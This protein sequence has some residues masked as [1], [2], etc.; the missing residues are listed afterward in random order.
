MGDATSRDE[1]VDRAL[2]WVVTNVRYTGLEFGKQALVPVAPGRTL[3]RG[4]G[5]CKD[6]STLLVGIL[7]ER[8]VDAHVALLNAGEWYDVPATLPGLGLFDH[9]IVHVGG[10]EPLWA[11]PTDRH[12]RAGVLPEAD[13]GRLAL[14]ASPTTR[15]PTRT[16]VAGVDAATWWEETTLDIEDGGGAR[17]HHRFGATGHI[18]SELRAGY[19]GNK[20]GSKDVLE[21]AGTWA[22][23][24]WMADGVERF[25]FPDADDT[26]VP[27]VEA[28]VLNSEFGLSGG[29]EALGRV[30]TAHLLPEL[31]TMYRGLPDPEAPRKTEAALIRPHSTRVLRRFVFPAGYVVEP[32]PGKL[33]RRTG[34]RWSSRGTG[35]PSWSRWVGSYSTSAGRTASGPRSTTPCARR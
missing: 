16:P 14:V 25:D 13:Q 31:S 7:R 10:R 11:D 9:A 21:W 29:D 17:V 8:G 15:K 30:D 6:Q 3:E 26:S 35:A 32:L 24:T 23:E 4:F 2:R 12:S 20:G 34:G 19:T 5:D 22:E 28:V 33:P 1:V 27:F 18:E